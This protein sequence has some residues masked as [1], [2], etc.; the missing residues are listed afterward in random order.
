MSNEGQ[1]PRL[2]KYAFRS[3]RTKRLEAARRTNDG[4]G[5]KGNVDDRLHAA[6][7]VDP[8]TGAIDLGKV[9]RTATVKQGGK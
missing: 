3:P 1:D 2:A 8:K 7:I 6:S 9:K 4:E 5:L